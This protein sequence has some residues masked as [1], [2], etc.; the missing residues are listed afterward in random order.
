MCRKP[1][2]LNGSRL[3]RSIE[4]NNVKISALNNSFDHYCR[5]LSKFQKFS[6][7]SKTFQ[8]I[9]K[10]S[11]TI[12]LKRNNK[13]NSLLGDGEHE[14]IVVHNRTDLEI[15][16]EISEIIQFGIGHALGGKAHEISLLREF[17]K[18]T[19]KWVSFARKC[20]ISEVVIYEAKGFLSQVSSQLLYISSKLL[21]F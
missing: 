20:N 21:D 18:L 19:D 16:S 13:L 2:K 5:N 1:A 14:K 11:E 8:Q 12:D 3:S 15:P 9:Q 7:R 4:Q 17:E 10:K 6:F